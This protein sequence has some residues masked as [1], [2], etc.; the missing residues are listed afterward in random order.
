MRTIRRLWKRVT[1]WLGYY[2]LEIG[3][4][5]FLAIFLVVYYAPLIFHTVDPGHV[6]VI[7]RRFGH[8]TVINE[9]L[10]EGT[11]ITWPWDK[12]FIYDARLQQATVE[13]HVLSSDGLGITV[14]VSYRYQVLA[15]NVGYMHQYIGPDYRDTL[16]SPVIGANLR[17]IFALYRPEQIY[18]LPRDRVQHDIQERARS[19]MRHK[20]NPK[21][22]DK[23]EFVVL[24]DVLINGIRLPRSI[25]MAVE[26]KNEQYQLNQEYDFRLLREAKETERKKIEAQGIREFQD[27]ISNGITEGYLRWKGIEA[28]LE[29]AK[30]PNAK[31]VVIGS[32]EHGMPLILGN[33]TGVQSPPADKPAEKPEVA[34][35]PSGVVPRATVKTQ[36]PRST[37]AVLP[38][39]EA[40]PAQKAQTPLSPSAAEPTPP[41]ATPAAAATPA[42]RPPEQRP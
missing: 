33:D 4:G 13:Y 28:T 37:N 42:P 41:V 3:I 10:E 2:S 21:A 16:I 18:S 27:I 15:D 32:G 14:E 20:F 36:S 39:K 34:A 6:A 8:G 29:L 38:S 23:M 9:H 12:L 17:E 7:W 24:E 5:V 31:V 19:D 30:S 40:A 26:R 11:Q 22:S 25:E 35:A 1:D